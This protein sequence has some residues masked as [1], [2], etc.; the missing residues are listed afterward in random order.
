M[1][2]SLWLKKKLNVNVSC[3]IRWLSCGLFSFFNVLIYNNFLCKVVDFFNLF[4]D[5]GRIL[6][7]LISVNMMY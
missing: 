1:L 5:D 2:N 6:I 3:K 4:V 7:K